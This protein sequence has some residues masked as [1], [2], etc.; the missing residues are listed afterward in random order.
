[1]LFPTVLQL[2]Y[3]VLRHLV[4]LCAA[5]RTIE[6]R[7]NFQ[8]QCMLD[9]SKSFMSHCFDILFQ[10]RRQSWGK[11]SLREFLVTLSSF[12]AYY[13]ALK[14]I[15]VA[16]LLQWKA[17]LLQWKVKS[18]IITA[19]TPSSV[20]SPLWTLGELWALVGSCQYHLIAVRGF[21]GTSRL[22]SGTDSIWKTLWDGV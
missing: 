1:M 9:A 11:S 19:S 16:T 17:T 10:K 5:I 14:Y 6:D 18:D 2:C 8:R 7:I 15:E 13:V 22:L 20:H 12:F 4:G 21:S 3:V